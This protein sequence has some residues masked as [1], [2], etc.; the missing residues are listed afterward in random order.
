MTYN[1]NDIINIL[2]MSQKT[3]NNLSKKITSKINGKITLSNGK[4]FE[5]RLPT[6]LIPN[7][8]GF[9][10]DYIKELDLIDFNTDF[11]L[12][13]EFL[14]SKEAIIYGIEKGFIDTNKLFD[15][16]INLKNSFL[17]YNVNISIY[18]E[19]IVF[20]PNNSKYDCIIIKNIYDSI[21]KTK[22]IGIGFLGLNKNEK[23]QFVPTF[24]SIYSKEDK[25]KIFRLICK[26]EI[27]YITHIK[28]P[29][30]KSKYLTNE[31]L[32]EKNKQLEILSYMYNSY[33]N[34]EEKKD[35]LTK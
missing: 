35:P 11:G 5:Y 15:K 9:N 19:N 32:E 34:L 4:T 8:L 14:N 28:S 18:D 13:R 24:T 25:D 27:S 1:S 29:K 10:L 6:H 20:F 17:Y 30:L 2:K 3:T 21:D 23:E 12:F 26:E 22:L 31:E 16:D 7:L 33:Y